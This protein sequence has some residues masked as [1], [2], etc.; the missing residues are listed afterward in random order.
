MLV[1]Q[2][3]PS[4]GT[5]RNN[6]CHIWS[7]MIESSDWRW[8]SWWTHGK[9]LPGVWMLL[10]LPLA[11]FLVK[12]SIAR[13]LQ[14]CNELFLRMNTTQSFALSSTG[15]FARVGMAGTSCHSH[16]SSPSEH[17]LR[18]LLQLLLESPPPPPPTTHFFASL[19]IVQLHSAIQVPLSH[20][21][22]AVQ[23]DMA[24]IGR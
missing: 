1:R 18:F 8:T 14:M 19:A 11:Y 13:C 22:L 12:M 24:G 21:S 16:Y 15:S 7:Q 23:T 10:I 20:L 2:V 17:C 3:L 4:S 9:L 6:E 5:Y